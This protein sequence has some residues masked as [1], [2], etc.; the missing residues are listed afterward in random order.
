MEKPKREG[1]VDEK[2]V[3]RCER[4]SFDFIPGDAIV[5]I[6]RYDGI[7]QI[8]LNGRRR[9]SCSLRIGLNTNCKLD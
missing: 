2:D 5:S 7:S 8:L 9:G 6:I 1:T 3:R 4:C